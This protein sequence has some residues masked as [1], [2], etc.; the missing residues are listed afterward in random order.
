MHIVSSLLCVLILIILSIFLAPRAAIIQTKHINPVDFEQYWLWGDIQTRP[1]LKTAKQLY[2]L[3]GQI[4]WDKQQKSIFHY[5]GIAAR[6]LPSRQ[7]IWL[8]FRNHHLNWSGQELEKIFNL[9]QRWESRNTHVIGIQIDFDAKTKKMGDYA[10]FLAKL[11]QQLPKHYQ[12]SITG[13]LD[14]TNIQDQQTLQL[15][16]ENIDELAIQTYQGSTTIKNYQQYLARVAQLAIP[17]K[18][19]YVQNG[20][21]RPRQHYEKSRYFKGHIIFLLREQKRL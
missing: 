20:I 3:Q 5:Q 4:S 7:K 13:L 18:V 14:W 6:S 2:I 15:L 8:V 17:F 16:R 1:Y 9:I 12:L 21:Y 19:G 11:R 10:Q